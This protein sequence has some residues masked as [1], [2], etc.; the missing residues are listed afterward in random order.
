VPKPS[1]EEEGDDSLSDGR[2]RENTGHL[3]LLQKIC[4]QYIRLIAAVKEFSTKNRM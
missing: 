1:R 2:R 4:V 3:P